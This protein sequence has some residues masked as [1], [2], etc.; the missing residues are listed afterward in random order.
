[1]RPTVTGSNGVVEAVASKRPNVRAA[2]ALKAKANSI[3]MRKKPDVIWRRGIK[4]HIKL[5][6]HVRRSAN[7]A[8]M[9]VKIQNPKSKI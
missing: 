9:R 3:W 2:S 5:M 7:W 6:P 1:M 4:S 8:I